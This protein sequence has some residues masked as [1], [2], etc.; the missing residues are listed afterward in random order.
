MDLLV[1]AANLLYV[2]AYFTADLLRLR[3]LTLVAAGCLAAYFLNQP[4]PL[5]NVVAWNLAF[6]ALNLWQLA[7]I[8][9]SRRKPASA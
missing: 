4:E 6:M 2:V 8:V 1:N 5:L 9:R 7:R 3:L